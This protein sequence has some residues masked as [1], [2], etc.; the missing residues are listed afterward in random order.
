[1]K[2]L[3]LEDDKTL[4]ESLKAYLEMEHFDVFSAFN[5]HEAYE[6][7]YGDSTPTIYVPLSLFRA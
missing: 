3:L 5:A 1:M 7:S 4:H 2:I 6:L